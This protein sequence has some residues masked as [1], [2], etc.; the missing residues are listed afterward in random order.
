MKQE[1][2]R[3]MTES[4]IQAGYTQNKGVFKINNHDGACQQKPTEKKFPKDTAG[5]I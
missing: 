5:S 3:E 2:F 1:L 4:Q